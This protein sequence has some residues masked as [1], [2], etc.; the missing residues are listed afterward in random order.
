M[1][2]SDLEALVAN[3]E[4]AS[5]KEGDTFF[6]KREA[7][8]NYKRSQKSGPQVVLTDDDMDLL[9][10]IEEID[11]DTPAQKPAAAQVSPKKA[12]E[13]AKAAAAEDI[14]NLDIEEETTMA[15]DQN[16]PAEGA[17]KGAAS[18]EDTVLNLDGLLED[19]TS[20]ATT[21]V[22]GAKAALG[23]K[24]SSSI[25]DDGGSDITL[26]GNISDETLLD[27]ELLD[28]GV[29]GGGEEETFKLD[30]GGEDTSADA[31]EATLLRGGS[32]RSMQMK[33]KEAS[34]WETLV[35]AATMAL[36]IPA[37]G[38]FFNAFFD[39]QLGGKLG[40][41]SGEGK[42]SSGWV[43]AAAEYS[44]GFIQMVADLF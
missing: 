41:G 33:R 18:P 11:L 25:L 4:I 32:S 40:A 38:V 16:K 36:L 2:E 35:M 39:D 26:E 3:G 34:R 27:T 15:K 21:P 13:P 31:T 19:D 12:A 20:E 44:R 29:E 5:I 7:I 1:S 6:F 9:N 28:L 43:L 42:Q 22:P 24:A 10:M 23:A 14:F 37:A 17:A 8:E 30:V